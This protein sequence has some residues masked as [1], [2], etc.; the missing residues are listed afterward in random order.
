MKRFQELKLGV[1]GPAPASVKHERRSWA[2]S[3]CLEKGIE[4]R[5]RVAHTSSLPAIIH[6]L[7]YTIA[8]KGRFFQIS[9][10]VFLFRQKSR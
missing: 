5:D 1:L 9:N 2:L 10:C 8:Y 6:C 4:D 7:L 3:E